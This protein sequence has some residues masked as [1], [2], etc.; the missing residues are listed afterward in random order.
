MVREASPAAAARLHAC[1]LKGMA[2]G[3]PLC[4]S[5]N[6]SKRSLRTLGRQGEF[7]AAVFRPSIW[8]G[9]CARAWLGP[10]PRAAWVP[11][12]YQLHP[13]V[14]LQD[15]GEKRCGVLAEGRRENI[16]CTSYIYTVYWSGGVAKGDGRCAMRWALGDRMVDPWTCASCAMRWAMSSELSARL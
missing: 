13:I 1:L 6:G 2:G 16:A 9:H 12:T 3:V 8:A 4:S 10:A 11:V 5:T 15:R 14:V 7:S